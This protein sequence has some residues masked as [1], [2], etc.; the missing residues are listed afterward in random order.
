MDIGICPS[1][2]E[3]CEYVEEGADDDF[4]IVTIRESDIAFSESQQAFI[5]AAE[6][7]AERDVYV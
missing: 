2:H 3:H 7:A 6:R 5:S 4:G 1:C